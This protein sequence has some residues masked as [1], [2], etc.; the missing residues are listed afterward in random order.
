MM[1]CGAIAS[2][3]ET[4]VKNTKPVAL[5]KISSSFCHT[6]LIIL[7]EMTRRASGPTTMPNA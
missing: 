7:D 6:H 4:D 5:E 1:D 3:E 2:L